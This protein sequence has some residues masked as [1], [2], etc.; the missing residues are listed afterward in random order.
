MNGLKHVLLLFLPLLVSG[1]LSTKSLKTNYAADGAPGTCVATENVRHGGEP[2]REYMSADDGMK[3]CLE[4]IAIGNA[5]KNIEAEIRAVTTILSIDDSGVEFAFCEKSSKATIFYLFVIKKQKNSE[6]YII[7]VGAWGNI[8]RPV[9]Y[10]LEPRSPFEE[11]IRAITD[12][13]I[14]NSSFEE[15]QHNAKELMKVIGDRRYEGK[16]RK[17]L[18]LEDGE[19]VPLGEPPR[20]PIL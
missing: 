6:I 16:W 18:M 19:I 11:K 13:I 15:E 10:L 17:F 2:L 7:T 9:F 5:S 20:R 14:Q 8:N 12:R 3:G 4:L 1:C